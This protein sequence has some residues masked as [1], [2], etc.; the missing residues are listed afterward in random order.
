MRSE[1]RACC[2][3]ERG[4]IKAVS[5]AN[6]SVP[7]PYAYCSTITPASSKRAMENSSG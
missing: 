5:K 6:L 7:S 1:T 3:Q 2:K 4:A